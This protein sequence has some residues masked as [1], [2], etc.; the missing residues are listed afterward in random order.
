MQRPKRV[1][2]IM[3]L[4]FVGRA[5]LAVVLPVLSA[6]GVQAC[7]LPAALFSTHTAGFGAVETTDMASFSLDALAHFKEQ[8]I[9]FDAIYTGYLCGRDQFALAQEAFRQYP[10]A[11]RVVDPALGDG[12]KTYNGITPDTV[13]QM[14]NL[15]AMAHLITPNYTESALLL[16]ESPTM[17]I[18][19]QIALERRVRALS[20]AECSVLVTS[21]PAPGDKREVVGCGPGG[22]GIYSISGRYTPGDYPG[23]GD[24]FTATT[25]G[26][27]LKGLS[28]P[29]AARRAVSFVQAAVRLTYENNGEARHGVW[30]E[31]LLPQ[32]ADH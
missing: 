18:P 31:P 16:G 3:D 29:E 2:C 22:T 5:S 9:E 20:G 19:E 10:N 28:L 25:T 32:L 24:V 1:L 26:L 15:C 8:K 12:G 4:T 21:V 11:I 27:F 6:C 23:T 17:D 7:P 14:K 30:F 13:A